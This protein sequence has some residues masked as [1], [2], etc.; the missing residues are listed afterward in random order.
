MV[1]VPLDVPKVPGRVGPPVRVTINGY[2]YPTTVAVYGGRC[3]LPVNQEHRIAAGVEPG[4]TITI[5]VTPERPPPRFEIPAYFRAALDQDDDASQAF[6]HLSI[7]RQRE[8][9]AWIESASR[10]ETR[11]RRVAQTIY[12]LR[13]RPLRSSRL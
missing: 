4:D 2:T 13:Q 8:Y 1:Q 6:A 9:V 5:Q 10:D 11:Q 3:Y 7:H 12:E